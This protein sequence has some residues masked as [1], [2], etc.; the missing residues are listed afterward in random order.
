MREKL[1]QERKKRIRKYLYLLV[2][3]LVIGLF[4]YLKLFLPVWLKNISMFSIKEII[5]EPEPYSS[6]VKGYI[7][8]PE[9]TSIFSVK[10]ADI[11]AKLKQVYFIEDCY[12]E[13]H[14]PDTLVIRVKIR[15]PWILVTDTR[16]AALMDRNGYFLPIQENFKGWNVQGI[17]IEQIGTRTSEIDKFE[18]L[19]GIEQWYNYYGIVNL[20]PVDTVI[21]NDPERIELISG[22]SKI[23]IHNNGIEKQIM[24]AKEILKNC[25]KNNF[26]FDYIDVRFQEPYIKERVLEKQ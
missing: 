15:T 14:I 21:I 22:D 5:V 16:S 20:F 8:V 23:Y 13:K 25:R 17:H 12:I 6:F 19:K 2:L 3:L 4:F 7:S 10:M 18:I 11:Y 1:I 26:S 24:T 9:N